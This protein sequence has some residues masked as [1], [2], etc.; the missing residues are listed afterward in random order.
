[1]GLGMNTGSGR[2]EIKPMKIWKLCQEI[3]SKIKDKLLFLL[4]S[5]IRRKHN[6]W[7]YLQLLEI[8]YF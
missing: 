6:V 1:V 3:S 4:T 5:K 8:E 2:W 7:Y